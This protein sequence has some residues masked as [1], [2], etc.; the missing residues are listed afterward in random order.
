MEENQWT[1]NLLLLNQEHEDGKQQLELL[2]EL[3]E[4]GFRSFEVRREFFFNI[5]EEI[6]AIRNWAQEH[7][8]EL[9][10]SIPDELFVDG[11]LNSKLLQYIKESH[12]MGIK[13]AKFNIG[14]YEHFQGDFK[15]S[16]ETLEKTLD[17]LE[18]NVEN[19]QTQTSGRI[20]PILKFLNDI[21]NSQIN[22]GYV[23]DLGNWEFTGENFFE[24]AE[25][26]KNFIRY[27]HVKDVTEGPEVRPLDEGQL[28]WRKALDVLPTNVPIALEYPV[29]SNAVIESGIN[30]LNSYK[31]G[32][33]QNE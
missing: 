17:G 27:I 26:L 13:K 4:L 1:A 10:Y 29:L 30:K 31:K 11:M 22:V 24:A 2:Q 16:F 21:K 7:N 5:D 28:D 33:A 15:A 25:T 9:F 6:P 18:I 19:D 14:D 3:Y 12:T 8:I 32:S 20:K 23:Y